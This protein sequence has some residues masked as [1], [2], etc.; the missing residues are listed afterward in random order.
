M[1][2]HCSPMRAT[3]VGTLKLQSRNP[4]DHPLL[5]PNY[6]ATKRDVEDMRAAVRLTQEIMEQSSLDVYRGERMSPTF[7]ASKS[8]DETVDDWVRT[9]TES[10]YHVSCTNKMGSDDMTVVDSS[11]KVHG[12]D[13]L[14]V[15]DASI[16]PSVV[17]GNLN[18][19]TIMMAEKAADLI[20]GNVPLKPSDAPVYVA[21]NWETQ[22]R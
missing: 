14:R 1:Q 11:T 13:G 20:L 10:A 2:A 7:D 16:M 22:Q 12:L 6:L 9:H 19:P 4:K 15:V 21:P 17:S 3:S 18:A 5:D 8:S